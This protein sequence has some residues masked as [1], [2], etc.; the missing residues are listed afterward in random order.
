M[1]VVLGSRKAIEEK[2][3]QKETLV[4]LLAPLPR[5]QAVEQGHKSGQFCSSVEKSAQHGFCYRL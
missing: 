5:T 1:P 2:V 4:Q 3:M